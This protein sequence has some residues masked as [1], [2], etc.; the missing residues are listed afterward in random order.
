MAKP[1]D[2]L[3]SA[4]PDVLFKEA[5]RQWERHNYKRGL[6]LFLLAAKAG[7]KSAPLNI[8]YAYDVGKGVPKSR[9]HAL[10]WY[11][12]SLDLGNAVAA[13]NI[14][15]IY[16]DEGKIRTALRWF[17]VAAERGDSDALLEIGK[18]YAGPLRDP[19]K[20]NDAFRR[21]LRSSDIT[22]ES[23]EQTLRLLEVV[24]AS[25]LE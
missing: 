15:T 25:N 13:S 3:R 24:R 12:K 4:P 5:S 6:Q 1:T 19:R 18:L 16:R 20:A 11:R 9:H 8:G 14:A 23:R 17:S 22:E 2:S 7:D 21:L 10:R